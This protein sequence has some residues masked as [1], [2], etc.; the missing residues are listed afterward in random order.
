MFLTTYK[1]MNNLNHLFE[2]F[3]GS[4]WPVNSN[5]EE[6]TYSP[7]SSVNEKNGVYQ[8]EIELPGVRKEDITVHV[9]SGVLL[10]KALRKKGEESIHFERRFRLADEVDAEKI[11]ATHENGVLLLEIARKPEQAPQRIEVK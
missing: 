4:N 2:E 3:F 6:V 9:E 5:S 8:V 10:V 11:T 7:R 1:P